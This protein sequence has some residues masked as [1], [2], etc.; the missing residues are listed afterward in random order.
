MTNRSKASSVNKQVLILEDHADAQAWL[1]EA[2]LMAYANKVD[3]ILS[4]SIADVRGKILSQ[5]FDLFLVDLNLPDGNGVDALS[6]A[7][8]ID[9]DLLC[10][11]S[12]IYSDD[13]HL[14]PALRAGAAGYILKDESKEAIASMLKNLNKGVPAIS[15]EVAKNILGY[16]HQPLP[17]A[18]HTPLTE[19]ERETLSYIAK[20]S[21]VK[22][23]A[24][25][26]AISHH[27]VQGYVK[28]IY[29]KLGVSSRAEMTREA[30]QA[31]LLRR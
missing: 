15:S 23:C 26:M 28:E 11:V 17:A 3:V 30:L 20:G 21:S 5:R 29:R 1:T 19:R 9:P 7:K 13:A 10:V 24:G 4:A 31:G 14:F 12:T 22:E 18:E 27:T 2:V 6:H 25:L 16:F 8:N